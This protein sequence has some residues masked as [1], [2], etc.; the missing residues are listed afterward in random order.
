LHDIRCVAT[1][2]TDAN[3]TS[4]W[5]AQTA[6]QFTNSAWRHAGASNLTECQTA[7]EF[8]PRCIAADWVDG[9]CWITTN[10]NHRH[11]SASSGHRSRLMNYV[12][13][14]YLVSRCSITPGQCFW[15]ILPRKCIPY[16]YATHGIAILICPSVSP[17]NVCTVTKRKHLTRKITTRK[18]GNCECI[19]I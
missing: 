4:S 15:H 8:D 5:V 14:Y 9:K 11:W 6:G 3:C 12:G 18:R 2:P 17:S 13:H 10:P 7:C 16:M 1:T 19:A